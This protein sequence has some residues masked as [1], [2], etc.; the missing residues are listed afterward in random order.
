MLLSSLQLILIFL[1][2]VPCLLYHFIA[3]NKSNEWLPFILNIEMLHFVSLVLQRISAAA[4]EGFQG[5]I[6]LK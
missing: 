5:F 1:S 6:I 2:T 3:G 4:A